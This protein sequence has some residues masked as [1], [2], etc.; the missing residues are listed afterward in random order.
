LFNRDKFEV[1][2]GRRCTEITFNR[3]GVSLILDGRLSGLEFPLYDEGYVG[4]TGCEGMNGFY[5]FSA[6]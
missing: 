2:G 1:P 3:E 5:G 6:G 4:F